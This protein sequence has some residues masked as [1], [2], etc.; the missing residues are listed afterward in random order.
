MDQ[1]LNSP[2]GV[3]LISGAT[4]FHPPALPSKEMH[5][6]EFQFPQLGQ[7]PR[8]TLAL[9]PPG[10]NCTLKQRLLHLLRRAGMQPEISGPQIKPCTLQHPA[11]TCQ[12]EQTA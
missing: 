11:P 3:C 12:P 6:L 8:D 1:S 4:A 5:W 2:P 10:S 9:G 7:Q